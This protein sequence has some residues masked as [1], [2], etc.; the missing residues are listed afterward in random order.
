MVDTGKKVEI[1][2]PDAFQESFFDWFDDAIDRNELNVDPKSH[3]SPAKKRKS[4]G[5]AVVISSGFVTNANNIVGNEA[6]SDEKEIP[7]PART[8]KVYLS[9][10]NL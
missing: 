6:E 3:A 10:I 4:I 1:G 5:G 2:I 8:E 9:G 7:S